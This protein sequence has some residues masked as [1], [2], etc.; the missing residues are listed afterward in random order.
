MEGD[1]FFLFESASAS[2]H[3]AGV[4]PHLN[5]SPHQN[6]GHFEDESWFDYEAES[7][8]DELER[9]EPPSRRV[10]HFEHDSFNCNVEAAMDVLERRGAA[11][12]PRRTEV[13]S[14]RPQRE[15]MCV[16]CDRAPGH[17]RFLEAFGIAACYDCQRLHKVNDFE[18]KNVDA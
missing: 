7:A 17:P 3:N 9:S 4:R 14:N 10:A 8:M 2:D 16:Q 1:G 12:P 18:S 15:G 5:P 13:H 6:H 11:P